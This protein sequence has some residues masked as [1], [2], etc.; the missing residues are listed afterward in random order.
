MKNKP[1]LPCFLTILLSSCS[2]NA[3]NIESK[4]FC[5]DT[6]IDI[7]L[8]EGTKAYGLDI[9]NIMKKYDELT[10]NYRARDVNNVY[11]INHTNEQVQID[12]GL[13]TLLNNS[14]AVQTMGAYNFD[15]FCGSL[16]K[17]WKATLENNQVLDNETIA[18]ELVKINASSMELMD[19]EYV[20]RVGEAEIDLGGIA[21]GYAL[22][23][24]KQYL[25]SKKVT[26]YIIDAGSSSILL[27]EKDTKDG[28]FN[29]GLKDIKNAYLKA[30][31]CFVSTSGT[32][33]QLT[34]IDGVKYSHI[35][36]PKTGSVVSLHDSVI[37]LTDSGYYGDALST[38]MM[39]N[40]IEEIKEIEASHNVK[41]IVID[42]GKISYKNDS[43]EV[44]YH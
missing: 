21:K 20:T 9:I 2:V 1:F 32:S 38:S 23:I 34:V 13:W 37:V 17:L 35:V 42:D 33:E 15:P 7:R 12:P 18:S 25:D 5:F 19:L 11:T 14:E 3:N 29:I 40:T 26:K 8:Y 30:K 39:M 16:A 41:A 10:D 31:N 6:Y 24:A 36:N 28:L 22:D 43:I 44:Y 4:I 27:G